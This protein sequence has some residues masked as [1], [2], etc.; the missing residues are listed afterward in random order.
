L[1]AYDLE[2]LERPPRLLVLSAC[3]AGSA[4]VRAGEAV[5]G[6][7]S[8]ALSFGTATVIAAVGP[9]GD[10]A[11]RN[12]MT[13]LHERLA[14]GMA[15]AEALAAVPRPLGALAFMCFGAGYA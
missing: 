9:V 14:L 15:P 4:D 7:V 10:A 3:D 12:L 5:M 6:L 11:T 1:I 13:G 2:R 8:A